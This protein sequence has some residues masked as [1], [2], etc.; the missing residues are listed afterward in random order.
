MSPS[1]DELPEHL[2]DDHYPE[3]EFEFDCLPENLAELLFK[4]P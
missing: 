1:E 2:E 4:D 3:E